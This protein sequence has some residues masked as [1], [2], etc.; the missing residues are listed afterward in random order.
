MPARA[1]YS[2]PCQQQRWQARGS[3]GLDHR[4]TAIRRSVGAERTEGGF[5]LESLDHISIECLLRGKKVLR[6][7]RRCDTHPLIP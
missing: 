5:K 4:S 2:V 3:G 6:G 1:Y 7:P